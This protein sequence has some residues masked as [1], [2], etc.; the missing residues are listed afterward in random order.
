VNRAIIVLCVIVAAGA[1]CC[2]LEAGESRT[3]DSDAY[4]L[5]I[6]ADIDA[7]TLRPLVIVFSPS[8]DSKGV[9]EF[10]KDIAEGYKLIVLAS[11]EFHNGMDATPVLERLAD[12]MEAVRAQAPVDSSRIIAAGFSGGGMCSHLF[13]FSHPALISAVIVNTGMI[14]EAYIQRPEV[15]PRGKCAVFLASPKDFRY[16][17]M[18]RDERFLKELGWRTAWIEFEYGHAVAPVSAYESAVQWLIEQLNKPQKPGVN[19]D[20]VRVFF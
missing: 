5:Y 4:I 15:Y 7:Q 17:E 2:S 19:S 11:K 12:G 6:P 3:V 9:I 10:W 13:A 16:E 20:K 14:H 8:G 18:R 1:W